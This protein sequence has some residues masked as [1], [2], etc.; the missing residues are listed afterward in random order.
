EDARDVDDHAPGP[1]DAAA[2]LRHPIRAAE[3]DV[4]DL[5][6]LLGRLPRARDGCSDPGLVDEHIDA[7]EMTHARVDECLAVL[8][9][10]DVGG[11]RDRLSPGGTDTCF[12][13]GEAGH[14]AGPGGQM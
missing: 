5:A 4:D 10:A 7:P 12:G 1:H 6:E 11:D 9:A 2:G 14:P 3:V 8:R 13:G